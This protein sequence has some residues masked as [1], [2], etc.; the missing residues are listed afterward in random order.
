MMAPLLG[1]VLALSMAADAGAQ[2]SPW[3]GQIKVSRGIVALEARGQKF[4]APGGRAAQGK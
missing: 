3:V 4:P 1:S 2:A